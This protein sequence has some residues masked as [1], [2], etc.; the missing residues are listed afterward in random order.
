MSLN[1]CR[2]L[3]TVFPLCA[4]VGSG[5]LTRGLCHFV[6]FGSRDKIYIVTVDEA[7]L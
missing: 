7:N 3:I 5:G 2:S 6:K 4:N 1:G